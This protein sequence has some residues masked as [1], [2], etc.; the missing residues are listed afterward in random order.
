MHKADTD[1]VLSLSKPEQQLC[2]LY[3][4]VEI[5]GKRGQTVH[6]HVFLL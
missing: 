3:E 5:D 6:V 1:G 4:V 2:K